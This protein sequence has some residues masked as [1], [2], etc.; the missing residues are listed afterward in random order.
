MNILVTGGSGFV[1]GYLINRLYT[2]YN[3]IFVV[4]RNEGKLLELKAKYHNINLIMGDIADP[5]VVKKALSKDNK[6]QA[7][8]HL[9]AFKHASHA[10]AETRRC[11]QTNIVGTMNLL[12]HFSGLEFTAMST[13]KA[14]DTTGVYGSTKRLMEKLIEEYSFKRHIEYR[15]VRCGNILNSTGSVTCL[16]R[17]ALLE[18]RELIVTDANAT[19]YFWTVDQVVDLLLNAQTST[20]SCKPI[21]PTEMKSIRI[22]ELLYAMQHKYG[23][24]K[25]IKKIGLQ[26]GEN[27]HEKLTE[28]GISSE[29]AAKYSFEEVLELI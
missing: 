6:I 13:D 10:E 19:R 23:K 21:I 18:G 8:Y 1:G 15:V 27:L 24:A 14:C 2:N 4:G 7:I 25:N 3:N 20:H 16:W 9:A 17:E 26:P 29:H 11:I 12:D 5:F 22:A 28:D